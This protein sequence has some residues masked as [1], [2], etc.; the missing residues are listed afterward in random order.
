MRSPNVVL[1]SLASKSAEQSYKYQRIYRNLY[2]P[3]FFYL[4][5]SNIYAKEGNMTKG[6]DE[7]TIDGMSEERINKIIERLK[8][9]SYQPKPVRRTYIPKKN[10]KLRP[11]GIPSIDDKLVQEVVRM[12]LTSIYEGSFHNRSHGFR[13]QRSCHTALYQ[14]KKT[15]TA[16]RW[17]VEGDI[18]GFFDNIDH[19]TLIRILR[20]RIEDEKF[21]DLIW[22]FLRAGYLEKW[23]YNKTY[24]GTPQG[25]IISPI[26]SN[27]YLNEFDNFMEGYKASFDKGNTRRTNPPYNQIK[28]KIT[29]RK[30]RIEQLRR[31]LDEIYEEEKMNKV[32]QFEQEI[33]QLDSEWRKYE[34]KDP[35]DTTYKRIQYVRYADDF[36]IGIIGNKDDAQQVKEDISE[37]LREELKLTLSDEKTLITN[38]KKRAKFLGYEIAI[39]RDNST[40]TKAN[41]V[42]SRVYFLTCELFMPKD[43]VRKTLIDKGAIKIDKTTGEWKPIHRPALLRLDPLEILYTYNSEIRGLYNYYK[44]AINVC[45]LNTFKYPMEYSLYK[46]LGNKY[47]ISIPKVKKKFWHEGSFGIK[48]KTKSGTKIAKLYNEGF[49]RNL[50]V[51]KKENTDDMPN[52]MIFQSR[53]NLIDRLKAKKCEWCSTENSPL[54]MH[55]TRK[56]KDLK[57]KKHWEKIMIA[58]NRKTMA[59]CIKC[60]DDLHAGKLD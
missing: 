11:L 22:K 33:E 4:A 50:M 2:N 26:L 25:G 27:L 51:S 56:L 53:S 29:F 36:L 17:F 39:R 60:H 34:S 44:L 41:G 20:K 49:K 40:K 16:V 52:E 30:K 57:G 28:S 10:G 19:H 15:F 35:M 9:F 48:Y 12:L 7:K 21:L 8:D 43:V 23:Q 58:R 6:T 55:H 14:I 32:L 54:E 59:L 46:T 24:S 45:S 47:K 13:P 5:Y 18:E 38:S 42:S 37:F 1:E 3:E 31:E